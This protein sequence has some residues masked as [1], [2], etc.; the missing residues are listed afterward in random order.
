MKLP[1]TG[2]GVMASAL[3]MAMLGTLGSVGG[4]VGGTLGLGFVALAS[5]MAE[6]GDALPIDQDAA[7]LGVEIA[8]AHGLRECSLGMAIGQQSARTAQTSFQAKS[9]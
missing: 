2:S 5:G 3:G 8:G 7:V 4:V 9:H 6:H 1:Y